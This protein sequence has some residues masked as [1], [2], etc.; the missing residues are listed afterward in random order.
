MG[1]AGIDYQ[2]AF[3][4]TILLDA[5]VDPGTVKERNVGFGFSA[6]LL[7]RK[8]D[9]TLGAFWNYEGMELRL[10]KRRPRIIRVERAGVPTYN[11]L[12][13]VANEDALERDA[14]RIRAFIGA[15]ARGTKELAE[16]PGAAIDGL[17]KAN[18]DLDP[19]LQRAAVRVTLPLF[20]PPEGKPY[21]YQ[22]PAGVAG[23]RRL[24]AREPDPQ[25]AAR[26]RRLV[27]Q[28]IPAGRRALGAR[29]S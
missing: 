13:L 9:A 27:H 6:A 18:P 22:D 20:L 29:A 16:D 2:S 12:V 21:G 4:R 26:R 24:D 3:L 5:G 7:T 17:L 23:V 19:K 14:G 10:K 25:G 1:T 28:R 11:E 15:L 8:V